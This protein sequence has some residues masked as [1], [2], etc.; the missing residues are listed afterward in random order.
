MKN[1]QRLP[2]VNPAV[3]NSDNPG[4]EAQSQ[5]IWDESI[6]LDGA[7]PVQASEIS[8]AEDLCV[9]LRSAQREFVGI[10]PWLLSTGD[11]F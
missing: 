8:P 1:R 10:A 11:L 7:A 9:G 2:Q 5:E 4:E 6:N 3:T